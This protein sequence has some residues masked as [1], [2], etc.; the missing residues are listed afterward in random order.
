LDDIGAL[1]ISDGDHQFSSKRSKSITNAQAP[2]QP[3]LFTF[4]VASSSVLAT[5]PQLDAV[6]NAQGSPIDIQ[7]G[8]IV[9]SVESKFVCS[10]LVVDMS[11]LAGSA[12]PPQSPTRPMSSLM[13]AQASLHSLTD[14]EPSLQP[15]LARIA[16]TIHP[17]PSPSPSL[18]CSYVLPQ[19]S[20]ATD[21]V[22]S[23]DVLDIQVELIS[24]DSASR[25]RFIVREATFLL[26]LFIDSATY[27]GLIC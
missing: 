27:F 11:N 24:F 18:F 7:L 19:P 4:H 12:I 23:D 20:V 1:G 17:P 3:D 10:N 2:T 6:I 21:Q 13:Q 26:C 25:I 5:S 14:T 8:S 15:D 9:E 16:S 22:E